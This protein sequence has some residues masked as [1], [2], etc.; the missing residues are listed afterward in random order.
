MF[1]DGR[2]R[3]VLQRLLDWEDAHVS[4]RAAVQ[5]V[6]RD[7]RGRVPPG[8]A[9]SLWQLVEHLRRTQRDILDFCVASDYEEPSGMEEYWPADAAPP[10]DAAWDDAVAAYVADLERLKALAADPGV[11]LSDRVPNGTGQTFLRELLLV[12]DH[13]AY[14][15]GQIVQVRRALGD[16]SS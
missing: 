4:F 7:L 2:G 15:V 10:G 6:P 9:H 11:T 12:A 8:F 1:D 16:W 13:T 14:H 3:E 5:A